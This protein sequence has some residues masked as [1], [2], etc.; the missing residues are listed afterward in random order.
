M[1]RYNGIA[2][3]EGKIQEQFAVIDT[4]V[5]DER[6]QVDKLLD[7]S[8]DLQLKVEYIK[9][10]TKHVSSSV[11]LQNFFKDDE[12]FQKNLLAYL[13]LLSMNSTLSRDEKVTAVL[14]QIQSDQVDL[15]SQK[16]A[17]NAA[18]DAYNNK[19]NKF[20]QF[21][22]DWLGFKDYPKFTNISA[23]LDSTSTPEEQDQNPDINS[24]N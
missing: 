12:S 20:P 9:L 8:R 18:V 16:L 2:N 10:S 4:T 3:A 15:R 1:Q 21:F 17:Y 19:R 13:D 5:Q 11:S 24:F 22:A 14:G 6:A 7:A 23:P